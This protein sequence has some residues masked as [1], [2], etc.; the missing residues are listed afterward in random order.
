MR[1]GPV[2]DDR[3]SRV[4]ALPAVHAL[5][6]PAAA[7]ARLHEIALLGALGDEAHHVAGL[8]RLAEGATEPRRYPGA[9]AEV[10]GEPPAAVFPDIAPGGQAAAPGTAA[11]IPG[12]LGQP[13]HDRPQ[14]VLERCGL[15]LQDGIGHERDP[16]RPAREAF[17][18]AP[19]ERLDGAIVPA[20]PPFEHGRPEVQSLTELAA[21]LEGRLPLREKRRVV[22]HGSDEPREVEGFARVQVQ[23]V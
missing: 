16:A 8:P 14:E 20:P 18:R 15:E 9:A 1:R 2:L 12:A 19:D 6:I 5:E 10:T 3:R 7:P 11:A 13:L 23:P 21:P 4:P 17:L 22:R